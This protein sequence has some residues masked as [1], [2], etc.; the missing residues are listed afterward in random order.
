[1]NSCARPF[2]SFVN[3]LFYKTRQ[4]TKN[5]LLG[6]PDLTSINMTSQCRWCHFVKRRPV[7]REE[8]TRR[9]VLAWGMEEKGKFF[10]GPVNTGEREL[11]RATEGAPL[12]KTKLYFLPRFV[13]FLSQKLHFNFESQATTMLHDVSESDSFPE[14]HRRVIVLSI[15][16]SNGDIKTL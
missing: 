8:T 6:F 13:S 5:S 7:P 4:W 16:L 12:P 2:I 9:C 1:M 14:E 15:R 3:S 10:G 11:P